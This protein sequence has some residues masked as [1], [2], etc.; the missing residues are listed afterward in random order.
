[1]T[2][3]GRASAA[4]E[5]LTDL[6]AR[7]RPASEALKDWGSAHRF[8]GSGDR[9]AIGSL[10]FDCLRQRASLGAAMED[11]GPRA[12]VLRALVS[13]W[14]MSADSVDTLFDGSRF[15]PEPLT[16]AE[17]AGLTR[18]LSPDVPAWVRGDY[19]EWLEDSFAAVFGEDA[20]A[21]GAALSV[22]APVDL[23][24]NTLKANRDKVL[25]ALARFTPQ[26]TAYARHGLR[27]AP[28][29]GSARTPHVEADAAH[30][31]GWLEV[32]DE[33]SQIAAAMTGAGPREQVIDLCAGAGGK[34]LAL[35]A[36]MENTGQ[37]Y[38]YDAN[39]MRLRPIF[40]RLRRAGARN[41]QVL[42]GGVDAG[43]APLKGRM[44]RV[45]IDAPCTGSGTWRRRPDAKWRL[46]P[47]MLS[48]RMADQVAVLDAGAGL[49]KPGGRLTYI[50]CSVLPGENREQVDSFLERHPD[51][52]LKPWREAWEGAIEA[53]APSSADGSDETLLMTP[54]SHGTDGFFVATLERQA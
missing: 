26:P 35:A 34:T 18:V 42:E 22:R 25:K 14:G 10:V 16:E 44:D 7:K 8:A 17:R 27:I 43:L 31:K 13:A 1:M 9:A 19:P 21:E 36:A 46:T 38:A 52:V 48:G 12:L 39:R 20:V 49:V 2:P 6:G 30:G 53:D 50:T 11:D 45:V 33:G 41:V 54:R 23:R 5:V 15:A 3:A 47:E 28:R 40:D 24:V 29:Q 4:I 51:F 32:Q 37:L